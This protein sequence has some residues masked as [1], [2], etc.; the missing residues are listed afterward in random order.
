MFLRFL[1]DKPGPLRLC[2]F[3][4]GITAFGSDARST[5]TIDQYGQRSW[6][7]EDGLPD[8]TIRS[9]TQ[10]TDGYLWLAANS[11]LVRFDGVSFKVFNMENVPGMINENVYTLCAARDGGLW[12]GLQAGGLLHYRNH[13]FTTYL[14]KDGLG[15]N[16]VSALHEYS[17]L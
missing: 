16:W 12:V 6:R 14:P 9:I 4:A 13:H 10:T 17:R 3:L 11:G 15:G 7:I 2:L 1:L 5:K 8:N